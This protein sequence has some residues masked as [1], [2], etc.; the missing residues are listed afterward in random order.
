MKNM[1]CYI[2]LGSNTFYQYTPSDEK[3]I[4]DYQEAKQLKVEEE[5][6]KQEIR[7]NTKTKKTQSNN[8]HQNYSPI[9]NKLTDSV[10]INNDIKNFLETEQDKSPIATDE[11]IKPIA[12]STTE[13]IAHS[14]PEI[15]KETSLRKEDES[16][17]EV[18]KIVSRTT[19]PSPYLSLV[20]EVNKEKHK[21]Q[22]DDKNLKNLIAKERL[23][24]VNLF[25]FTLKKD[26]NQKRKSFAENEQKF[27]IKTEANF[28][29]RAKAELEQLE[30]RYNNFSEED[31]YIEL[32]KE[33]EQDISSFKKQCENDLMRM[34][35]SEYDNYHIKIDELERQKSSLENEIQVRVTLTFR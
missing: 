15:L 6:K 3:A 4:A 32:I 33:M 11:N 7:L 29:E 16:K 2:D 24:E 27:I 22:Y 19:K 30:L 18:G 1:I 8:S 20:P 10:N 12:V 31:V 5:S 14:L 17:K 13:K 35:H 21:S 34:Q 26:Y 23:A 28:Q 9:S 25:A